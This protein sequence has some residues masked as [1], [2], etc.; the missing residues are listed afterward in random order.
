MMMLFALLRVKHRRIFVSGAIGE[1]YRR[2][3]TAEIPAREIRVAR[4]SV[5]LRGI[6][7]VN[8]TRAVSRVIRPTGGWD[9]R[10]F[11]F[12]RQLHVS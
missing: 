9:L 4:T 3:K 2:E 12:V 10:H 8:A 1:N 6:M 5:S 11:D 7:Y